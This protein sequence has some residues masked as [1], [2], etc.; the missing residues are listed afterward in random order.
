MSIY[1]EGD[2]DPE[3]FSEEHTL[4]LAETE[5]LAKYEQNKDNYIG[6]FAWGEEMESFTL[7]EIIQLAKLVN[8]DL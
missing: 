4:T 6:V 5:L 2:V 1:E 3:D 8:E 7:R